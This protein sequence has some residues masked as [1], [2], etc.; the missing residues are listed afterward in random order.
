VQGDLV[1]SILE[2]LADP[3]AI[4]VLAET[5]FV[6]KGT[7]KG[8]KSVGVAPQYCG[9]VGKIANCQIGVFVAYA[10]P[11]GPVLLDRELYLP[12]ERANDAERRREA[13]VP[14][15]ATGVPKPTLGKQ[16]LERAF[17]AGVSSRP[18]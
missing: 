5:G 2:H 1:A 14:E 11:H 13:G 16:V 10:T 12:R 8:T 3:A 15:T 4:R 6:K 9:T 7:K 18:G 17:T